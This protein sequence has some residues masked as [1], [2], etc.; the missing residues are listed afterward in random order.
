R[1]AGFDAIGIE[2]SP[3]VVD[4]AKRTFDVP[5]LLGGIEHQ[6]FARQSFD[7]VVLNDVLE[8]LNDPHAT[9]RRCADLLKPNGIML[10]QTPSYPDPQ[11]YKDLVHS[12]NRFAEMLLAN[13]HLYLFSQ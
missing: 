12:D 3:W 10:I 13:E 5:M 11:I 1:W 6:Q 8:H 7:V 2:L 9:L 4:F